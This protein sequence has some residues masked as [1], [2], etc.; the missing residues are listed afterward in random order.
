MTAV[1]YV[2]QARKWARSL[3]EKEKLRGG[4]DSVEAARPIVSRKTG[5]PKGTLV[6][7]RKNRL[8]A[9]AVH[10]YEQLR[11]GVIRELEAELRHVSHEI[12]IAR[13]TGVDPRTSQF[14]SALA[15]EARIRE[16]LGLDPGEGGP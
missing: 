5:V 6:S 1:A 15:S 10:I 2:Q 3:E 7:L 4:L 9:I 8:K 13:Q 11:S 16:A 14:Q 12:Q